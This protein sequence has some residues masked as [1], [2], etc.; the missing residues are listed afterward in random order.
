[1]LP[2][3]GLYLWKRKKWLHSGKR[4]KVKSTSRIEFEQLRKEQMLQFIIYLSKCYFLNINCLLQKK[5]EEIKNLNKDFKQY[6]SELKDRWNKEIYEKTGII[7]KLKNDQVTLSAYRTGEILQLL[8]K[9]TKQNLTKDI[10]INSA[11]NPVIESF[12][13]DFTQY[14]HFIIHFI[15]SPKETSLKEISLKYN[16][17]LLVV[18][19]NQKKVL[20]QYKKGEITSN[21][22][23]IYL[24]II[25]NTQNL[26][27]HLKKLHESLFTLS[28]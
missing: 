23:L 16:E 28:F 26:A 17:L 11:Q 1:M 8:I 10:T 7:N 20:K 18:E 21:E 19:K 24:Q 2:I 12:S 6:L 5:E 14:V 3:W 25:S 15:Y 4:T 22:S 27:L 13:E 9:N